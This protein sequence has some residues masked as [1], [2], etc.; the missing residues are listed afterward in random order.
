MIIQPISDNTASYH[1]IRKISRKLVLN[2]TPC[3]V[4]LMKYDKFRNFRLSFGLAFATITL[5]AALYAGYFP[6]I[7]L[8]AQTVP[9]VNNTTTQQH[10]EHT[11]DK[12]FINLGVEV[13]IKTIII[14]VIGSRARPLSNRP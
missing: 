12:R 1:L 13:I 2:N 3:V 6:E 14:S 9:T 8:Y 10:A 4:F 5:T 11:L 7:D